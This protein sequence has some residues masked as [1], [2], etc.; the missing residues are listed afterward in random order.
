MEIVVLD[1]YGL[2]PGDLSWEPIEALGSVTIYSHSTSEEL[3][4]RA[5]GADAVLVDALPF[6]HAT[7]E[8][9]PGL[10]YIGLFST[11]YEHI[12]LE[13]AIAHGVTVCNV[14][15]Y[16]TDSVAQAAM[17]LVLSLAHRVREYDA[18]V[19]RGEWVAGREQRYP[20][21]PL[22]ELRGKVFG[23]VGLGRIGRATAGLAGAFGMRVLGYNRTQR[24]EAAQDGIELVELEELLRRSDVVSLHTALSDETKH[25]IDE[26]ALSRMKPGALLINTARGGLVDDDALAAA[27]QDGRIGGA[28]LDVLGP[29]EPP[30]SDN[31]LLSAPNCIITPHIAWATPEAR[32]RCL[33]GAA[34][35]LRAF[36]EG[37]AQNV[38]AAP[39]A[40][41][42]AG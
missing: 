22:M 31:P 39:G 5:D 11:G 40:G 42:A 2:N 17:A 7:F 18:L 15:A 25:L 1:G 13:A 20:A 35:N 6:H 30:E 28:G 8:S 23:A 14:P 16:G 32:G 37:R 10:Q 4:Q 21:Q 12:D 34:A 29:S 24:A 33:Q 26:N 36:Q 38:V 19:Q 3:K 9:L 27:L 41:G